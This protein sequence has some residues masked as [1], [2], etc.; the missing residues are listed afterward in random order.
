MNV[1]FSFKCLVN[2]LLGGAQNQGG[3]GNPAAS[4]FTTYRK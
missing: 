4:S 3:F 2:N 1:L